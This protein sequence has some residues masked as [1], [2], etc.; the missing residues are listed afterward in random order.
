VN[1]VW[2]VAFGVLAVL[3][4]TTALVL[5]AALRQIGIL[6]EHIRAAPGAEVVAGLEPGRALPIPRLEPITTPGVEPFTASVSL[7]GY[8]QPRCAACK[9]LPRY[10]DEYMAKHAREAD[11]EVLLVTDAEIT[12]SDPFVALVLSES[13]S[14]LYRSSGFSE[15]MGIPGSPFVLM[16]ELVNAEFLRVLAA[17]TAADP[18]VLASL[19]DEGLAFRDASQHPVIDPA[20]GPSALK[21]PLHRSGTSSPIVTPAQQIVAKHYSQMEAP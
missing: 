9:D 15:K 11:I 8:I 21:L 17:G 5:V 18:E 3:S 6:Y 4:V 7:V 19:V 1:D 13:E 2:Y 10:A 14:P 20:S 12:A 16:V